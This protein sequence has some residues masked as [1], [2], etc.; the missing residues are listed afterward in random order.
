M[1]ARR[2]D[3]F[4]RVFAFKHARRMWNPN[5][6]HRVFPGFGCSVVQGAAGVLLKHVVNVLHTTDIALP[7]RFEA[8]IKPADGWPERDAI[9]ANFA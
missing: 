6:K 5:Q 8:F 3:R 9:G 7:N 1:I 2:K 4:R